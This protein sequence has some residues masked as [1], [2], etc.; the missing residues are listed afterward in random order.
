LAGAGVEK[1]HW[2]S[3]RAG[4]LLH[5]PQRGLGNLRVGRIDQRSKGTSS[6]SS[7]SCLDASSRLRKLIPV[8]LPPGRARLATRPI[9]TGSSALR[10]RIGI[11][12]VAALAAKATPGPPL[13]TST[14]TLR[15]TRSAASAGNRS[16][17][18]SAQ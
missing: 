9:R 17:R 8:R 14:A 11:V 10:K 1:L 2:Q 13:A 12:V 7:S 15:P 3:G 4:D 5:V 6:R 18:L 16:T